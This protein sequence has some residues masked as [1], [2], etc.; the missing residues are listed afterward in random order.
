VEAYNETM[1]WMY[2]EDKALQ[3][4]AEAVKVPFTIAKRSRDEFYPKN[5][6]RPNRLSGVDEAMADAI[7]LK[8]LPA[9][10]SKEQLDQLFQYQLPRTP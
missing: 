6:L 3:I 10:L 7:A 1:D 2:A 8:F 4:Y 9:A 5:N